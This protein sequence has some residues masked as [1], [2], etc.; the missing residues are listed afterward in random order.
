MR[1]S[2]S[3]IRRI[4]ESTRGIFV[5]LLYA[6]AAAGS[7]VAFLWLSNLLFRMTIERL[8]SASLTVFVL[9]SLGVISIT[10]ILPPCS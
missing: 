5:S 8:A 1:I 9:G 4:P 7:A 3:D 2:L 6:A 10:S